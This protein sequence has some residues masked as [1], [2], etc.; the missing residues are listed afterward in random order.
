MIENSYK[1]KLWSLCSLC[2]YVLAILK[3][4][5]QVAEL[6]AGKRFFLKNMLCRLVGIT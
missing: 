6:L 2:D 1:T 5:F 3:D 4:L